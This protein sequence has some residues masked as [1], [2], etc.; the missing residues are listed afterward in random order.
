MEPKA[1][2]I[3]LVVLVVLIIL[4]VLYST[5]CGDSA[6]TLCGSSPSSQ[7]TL[8]DPSAALG[9]LDGRQPQLNGILGMCS[10]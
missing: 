1:A 4:I 7:D 9:V 5:Y 8:D 2:Q 6:Y 3:T 10:N